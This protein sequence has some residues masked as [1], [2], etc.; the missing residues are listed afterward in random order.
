MTKRVIVLGGLVVLC[1]LSGCDT[2][3][4]LPLW[5]VNTRLKV[6]PAPQ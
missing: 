2:P 3:P 6:F 4:S 5:T 1:I